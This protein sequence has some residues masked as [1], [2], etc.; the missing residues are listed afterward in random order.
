MIFVLEVP[1]AAD[2]LAWFAFDLDDLLRKIEARAPGLL[3]DAAGDAATGHA[4]P[5]CR[6][7]WT[8]SEAT[9]AFES[10][11]D[12]LWQGARWRARMALR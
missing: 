6:I 1:D 3:H 10:S 5:P 12:P 11:T 4:V 8:E 9:A 2:P 7:F